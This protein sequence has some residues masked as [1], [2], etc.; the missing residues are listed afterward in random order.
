[1]NFRTELFLNAY[2]LPLK[3]DSKVAKNNILLSSA[4]LKALQ[5]SQPKNIENYFVAFYNGDQLIGGALL[6]YLDF[7]NHEIFKNP[8]A[9]NL[10]NLVMKFL[11]R[12]ILIVGNNLVTGQNGFNFD[13]ELISKTQAIR[14][15]EES[16]IVIQNKIQKANLILFK[17]YEKTLSKIIK[18]YLPKGFISFSVQP[19]MVLELYP[20]W[21]TFEDYLQNLNSKYRTRAKTAKKKLGEIEKNELSL[22]DIFKYQKK[23]HQLYLEVAK[24]ADF[25]TF[26]LPEKHF[27]TLKKYLQ[28][29]FKVFAYFENGKILS[30][31]T[32]FL[33]YENINTYFLG[34]DKVHQKSRQ[35]YLNMLLDMVD[36]SIIEKK[37]NIIFGRTALEIKSTIGAKPQKIFGI[38]KHQNIYLNLILKKLISNLNPSKPWIARQP[39]KRP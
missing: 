37:K 35:I 4:F 20:Q 18:N 24:E 31:Y 2:E 9:L 28:E 11:S 19:N 13:L 36:F 15:L 33:N 34:Y 27:Y 23:L 29:N 12:R 17:D 32:L 8:S 21:K 10:N 26:L 16:T 1:M 5:E 22:E 30:F 25:N 6:Q 7:N 14:L 3:W 38:V 39:F